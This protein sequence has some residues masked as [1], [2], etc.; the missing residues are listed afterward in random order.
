MNPLAI[1]LLF[2]L[3]FSLLILPFPVESRGVELIPA[4]HNPNYRAN[5]TKAL[6]H[7]YHRY[8]II[9][10][11]GP[12]H[13]NENNVLLKR[14][15]NGSSTAVLA[16]D[17]INDLFYTC[18]VLI[19]TPPQ[20]LSMNFD[21][22]SA[23][24]WVWSI[25]IL[26]L[27]KNYNATVFNPTLSSTFRNMSGS[28][29]FVSYGDS[30]WVNG[31]VGTDTLRVG[32]IAIENQAVELATALASSFKTLTTMN[33]F[34]GLSFT[35]LNK[36]K[37]H[38]VLTPVENMAL[39]QA[40]PAK[41]QLFTAYLGSYKDAKD[42]DQGRSFYTFGGIN[43]ALVPPGQEPRYTSVNDTVGRWMISSPSV[44]INGQELDLPH[45]EA[46]VDT[47]TTLMFVK[48]E[49]CRAF[50][51]QIPGA[52]LSETDGQWI[53]PTQ[54][55]TDLLPNLSVAVGDF[56]VAINKEQFAFAPSGQ[57][58]MTVGAI[59]SRISSS[60]DIFGIPFFQNVYAIFDVGR[61]RFGVVKRIDPTP[62]GPA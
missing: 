30:S 7:A 60:F 62:N 36:V 35:N 40:I 3:L 22:G 5:A 46:L 52:V 53:F 17:Y 55:P 59:Q 24:T 47:G 50:Y 28:F 38:P 23:D 20:A 11:A 31:I 45:N 2:S 10:L 57:A 32:N 41:Q 1:L 25:T 13:R 49:V 61:R 48:E 19:G 18:P 4:Y 16:D 8:G 54:I 29:F 33:G 14:Q 15:K 34:L 9:P 58:N 6:L 27:G 44:V 56:Q 21:T 43:Q 12:Y 39:Q 37:P 26:G 42:P 51:G